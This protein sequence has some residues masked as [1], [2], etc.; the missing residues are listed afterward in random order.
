MKPDTYRFFIELQG[1]GDDVPR[2]REAE[3]RR[4]QAA[5]FIDQL[6]FWLSEKEL[7]DDVSMVVTALGQVQITCA[8]IVI[9]QLNDDGGLPPIASIRRGVALSDSV[10]RNGGR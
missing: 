10:H 3:A 2:N 4:A 8:P 5:E 7:N 6:A 9:S 1:P